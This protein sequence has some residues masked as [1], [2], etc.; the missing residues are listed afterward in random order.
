M[1]CSRGR[2]EAPENP[3]GHAR[4]D[5]SIDKQLERG[6]R[7][8]WVFPLPTDTLTLC[9]THIHT[10]SLTLHH[11]HTYT[12]SHTHTHICSA[13][14]TNALHHTSI[15]ILHPTQDHTCTHSIRHTD[16]ITHVTYSASHIHTH[17]HTHH[18]MHT[19]YHP[20]TDILF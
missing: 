4:G 9:C 16:G 2:W 11:K 13:P 20:Y 18:I 15:H 3:K 19:L 10:T 7:A 5:Q 17:T 6:A 14:H 8:L 12:A 1:C